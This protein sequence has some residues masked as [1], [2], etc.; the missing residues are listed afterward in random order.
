MLQGWIAR[1]V[2]P[3]SP[4]ALGK[5][6]PSG[7]WDGGA[8]AIAAEPEI[9]LGP[10]EQGMGMIAGTLVATDLGW[11]PV[12]AVKPGDL[13]ITFDSGM[14]PVKSVRIASLWTNGQNAPRA[15]WPLT[16]PA[17]ALGNRTEVT[18]LPEQ[19]LL[20]ESDA[21]VELYG[22]PF[23]LVSAA[24]LDGHRGIARR[25]PPREISVITLEFE[26]D[27]VIYTN[28]TLLVHCPAGS[29][30]RIAGLGEAVQRGTP[31]GYPQLTEAQGRR[32]VAAMA[33]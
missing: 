13:V 14:R 8:G 33:D 7:A 21:A 16:V 26:R 2:A 5:M 28:G 1:L 9:A 25:Q 22:Q 15:L 27:E 18:V 31:A 6:D 29:A 20:I 10:I 4:L 19:T 30:A 12:E 24:V 17:Q 23:M 32:L 3:H 11:R